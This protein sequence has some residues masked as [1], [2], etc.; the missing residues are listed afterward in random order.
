MTVSSVMADQVVISDEVSPLPVSR[1]AEL[2][3]LGIG[4]FLSAL[5]LG[6][7]TAAMNQ[8]DEATFER[9]IKPTLAA[10]N[11]DASTA[12]LF[13]MAKTLG[14]WFG[15]SLIVVLLLSAAGFFIAR[16]RPEL[17]RAGFWV[18]AAGLAC[19]LGSQLILFPIAFLFFVSAGFFALRPVPV[20]S[21]P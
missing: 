20:R 5:F 18:A 9:V 1:K 13:E 11:P 2:W 14:A 6:G 8:V 12:E 21:T 4:A 17:K 3:F 7:F 19:L 15:F 10:S 16:R